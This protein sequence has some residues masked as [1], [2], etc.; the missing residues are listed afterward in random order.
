MERVIAI[1]EKVRE[2][3]ERLRN[4]SAVY[5]FCSQH[6]NERGRGEV[7]DSH[8]TLCEY[9]EYTCIYEKGRYVNVCMCICVCVCVGENISL[10]TCVVE[11]FLCVHNGNIQL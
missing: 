5:I 11:Q 2:S 6:M 4:K 3:N 10:R 7:K 9:Y 8:S 1:S